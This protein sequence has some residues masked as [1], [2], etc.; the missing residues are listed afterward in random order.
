MVSE[1]G[2]LKNDG[3]PFESSDLKLY[4]ISKGEMEDTLL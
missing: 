1:M 4:V 2:L 3:A